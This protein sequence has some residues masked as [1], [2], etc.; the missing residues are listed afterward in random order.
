M[1]KK[2]NKG[3]LGLALSMGLTSVQAA[4]TKHVDVLLI[5]GGIMSTT[6]GVWLNELEPNT[7]MQMIERLTVW[8]WKAPMAGTTQV[9]VTR[10]WPN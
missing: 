2:M 7:S 10:H 1:L 4:E 8:R 6:L 9:R 3:L 5:G